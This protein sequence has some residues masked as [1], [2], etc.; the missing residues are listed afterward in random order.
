MT[1]SVKVSKFRSTCIDVTRDGTKVVVGTESGSFAVVKVTRFASRTS[2]E[3][4]QQ[5]WALFFSSPL[6]LYLLGL[7]GL[8]HQRRSHTSPP[9]QFFAPFAPLFH[10]SKQC[11]LA[12]VLS[13]YMEKWPWTFWV[14]Y[15][16]SLSLSSSVITKTMGWPT[17]DVSPIFPEQCLAA[18][19]PEVSEQSWV[20]RHFSWWKPNRRGSKGR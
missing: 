7:G 13:C 3:E 19:T 6:P 17:N 2:F 12:G 20:C 9:S 18:R 1:S 14:K 5:A 15:C 10:Y 16:F 4:L 8:F 11:V